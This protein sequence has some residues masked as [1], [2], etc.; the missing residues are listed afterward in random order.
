MKAE[1]DSARRV[2]NPLDRTSRNT[3]G[4][5]SD[6][7]AEVAEPVWRHVMVDNRN[8]RLT[9]QMR[10]AWRFLGLQGPAQSAVRLLPSSRRE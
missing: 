1:S 8:A 10:R 9:W 7:T 6:H 2:D 4:I 3:A 5:L